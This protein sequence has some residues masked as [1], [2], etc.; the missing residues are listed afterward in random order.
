MGARRT[1]ATTGAIAVTRSTVG[2]LGGDGTVGAGI[3]ATAGEDA[4]GRTVGVLG[5]SRRTT[6]GSAGRDAGSGAGRPQDRYSPRGPA[7]HS[8]IRRVSARRLGRRTTRDV[9]SGVGQARYSP[10]DPPP[11]S[12]ARRARSRSPVIG[13]RSGSGTTVTVGVRVTGTAGTRPDRTTG[14]NCTERSGTDRTEARKA[15][16][17]TGPVRCRNGLRSARSS[18]PINP[19]RDAAGS[20]EAAPSRAGDAT[21]LSLLLI[22]PPK[23]LSATGEGVADKEKPRQ[24]RRP[25]PPFPTHPG[26][27]VTEPLSNHSG[28]VG[29]PFLN[30]GICRQAVLR[31][32]EIVP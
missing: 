10:S 4:A 2:L 22:S 13:R 27:R 9:G 21:V 3:S 12:A 8:A 30:A 24:S 20:V 14:A 26:A 16:V 31:E 15:L 25:R 1:A 19:V 5:S 7:P 32:R 23:S 28:S 29:D 17:C 6:G 18:T 11:H